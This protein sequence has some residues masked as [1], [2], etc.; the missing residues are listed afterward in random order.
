MRQSGAT[1][2][3]DGELDDNGTKKC[4]NLWSMSRMEDAVRFVGDGKQPSPTGCI[5][6]ESNDI[7]CAGKDPCPNGCVLMGLGEGETSKFLA[8]QEKALQ[9]L[10]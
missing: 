4:V 2:N 5:N 7:E 10:V 6:M 8:L 9:A 1:C 3:D